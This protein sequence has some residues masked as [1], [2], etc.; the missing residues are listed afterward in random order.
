MIR[1]RHY[2]A[3]GLLC[4]LAACAT[5]NVLPRSF[6][7]T[8][9]E[10]FGIVQALGT[11]TTT[12]LAAN[13]ISPN[14]AQNAKNQAQTLKDGLDIAVSMR[15]SGTPGAQDKLDATIIALRALEA[16]LAKQATP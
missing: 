7:S 5:Y 2:A 12:L 10:G 3:L 8:A 6:N 15:A 11:T 1:I 14:D 13:K 4:L 9:Q 16:Y